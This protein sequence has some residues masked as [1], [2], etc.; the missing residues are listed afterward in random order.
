MEA[1]RGADLA[2]FVCDGSRPLEQED[3]DA[4]E[5]ARQARYALCLLN[6]QDLPSRVDRACLPF[7]TVLP[8]SAKEGTGL[9]ALAPILEARFGPGGACDGSIV[10][11]ARQ[12]DAVR[13]AAEALGRARAGLAAGLTPDAVLI[14]VEEAMEAMGELTGRTVRED[15]TN[16]IFERFCVGK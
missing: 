2:L 3:A 4:M 9:E 10:T 11:N 8:V 6:K 14:D 7:E 12:A 16:R 5:A 13:R 15:I 1:A